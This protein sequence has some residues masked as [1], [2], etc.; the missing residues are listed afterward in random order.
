MA[1]RVGVRRLGA[2]GHRHLRAAAAAARHPLPGGLDGTA[3]RR[4][5]GE[6]AARFGERL[7]QAV[8]LEHWPAFGAS[9]ARLERLLTELAAG[10]HA[11]HGDP[12][13]SVTVISGD[14]HHS[15]LAAV[16][17]PGSAAGQGPARRKPRHSGDR[18]SAVHEVVCSPF[19]QSM[20]PMRFAQ[21]LASTWAAGVSAPPPLAGASVPG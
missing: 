2:R 16:D 4:R 8:D 7:R 15:Y 21:R 10:R 9:F 5:L 17:L 14:V 11:T 12:P 20:P 18:A 6:L 3:G 13:V 1:H 19:H